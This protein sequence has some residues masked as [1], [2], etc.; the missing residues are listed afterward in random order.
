L[1][2]NDT[3]ILK[4]WVIYW[5]VY[6]GLGVLEFNFYSLLKLIPFY[7]F[8]KIYLSFWLIL[9]QTQGANFIYQ[10]YIEPFISHYETNF[11]ELINNTLNLGYVKD[12]G[13]WLI[14]LLKNF[15]HNG[16]DGSTSK[17]F[18]QTNVKPKEGKD[19]TALTK[20]YFDLFA[21]SFYQKANSN[22]D[23]NTDSNIV[24]SLFGVFSSL[25]NNLINNNNNN[26]EVTARSITKDPPSVSN[27]DT[28][29]TDPNSTS[30][31]GTNLTGTLNENDFDVVENEDYENIINVKNPDDVQNTKAET[32]WFSYWWGADNKKD[33]NSKSK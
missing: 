13:L 9:P 2:I 25:G 24:E 17:D 21:Q 22:D 32:G 20:S 4:P 26:N 3:T 23:K 5:L 1:K 12:Q 15:N 27:V 16:T 10:H 31:S 29:T 11:D 14:S 7:S 28:N 33:L 19:D 30:G 8:I 6:S 18:K